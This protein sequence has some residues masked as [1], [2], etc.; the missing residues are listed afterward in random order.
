MFINNLTPPHTHTH[1]S[2]VRSDLSEAAHDKSLKSLK[3]RLLKL[4]KIRSFEVIVVL[5]QIDKVG[6]E[7]NNGLQVTTN[8]LTSLAT[9]QTYHT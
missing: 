8:P 7:G 4:I 3:T 2:D 1:L 6:D 9:V 5:V